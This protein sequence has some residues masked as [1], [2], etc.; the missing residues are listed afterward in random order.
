MAR[1][2]VDGSL[3]GTAAQGPL[4]SG[5]TTG[6]SIAADNPPGSGSRLV[7]L[8]DQLRVESAARTAAEICGD[9]GRTS[10]P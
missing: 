6:A 8:I 10:C 3:R 7:G 1:I 2:Y 9:A 4:G 5:G